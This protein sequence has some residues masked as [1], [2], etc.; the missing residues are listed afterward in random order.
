[1]LIH[2]VDATQDDVAT[3]Y[4]TVRRELAE[5]GPELAARSELVCLNKVDALA[6]AEVAAKAAALGAAA[7]RPVFLTS[8]VTRRGLD[9]V[10][11]AAHAE[12]R[13]ARAEVP[14]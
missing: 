13:A 2:L 6:D 3:A 5:Y 14:A 10:L 11:P 7:H 8:G 12:I 4:H 1:V 9:E